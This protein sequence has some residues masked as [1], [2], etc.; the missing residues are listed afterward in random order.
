MRL[1][2]LMLFLSCFLY[3]CGGC[4]SSYPS[5]NNNARPVRPVHTALTD[6]TRIDTLVNVTSTPTSI[7]YITSDFKIFTPCNINIVANGDSLFFN[8]V[9]YY[10]LNNNIYSKID[11]VHPEVQREELKIKDSY[12][13]VGRYYYLY[14]IIARPITEKIAVPNKDNRK[15]KSYVTKDK[16]T[17]YQVSKITG[18]STAYLSSKYGICKPKITVKFN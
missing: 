13:K 4:G 12:I 18:L 2:I 8:G 5:R 15:F 16:D 17:W 7:K 6:T 3:S 14:D 1:T 11:Y 10:V 9:G